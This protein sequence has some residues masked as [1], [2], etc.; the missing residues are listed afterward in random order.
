M[1][2]LASLAATAAHALASAD[3]TTNA[4]ANYTP[5]GRG[6]AFGVSAGGAGIGIG[7]VFASAIQG[8]ARQ[9]EQSA[10]LQRLMIFGFAMIEALGLIGLLLAFIL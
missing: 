9:P 5:I 7:L 10:N 6:I 4:V 8:I 1:L 2:E 3:T